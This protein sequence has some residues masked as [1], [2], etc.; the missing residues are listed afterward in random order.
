MTD[1]DDR[2]VAL[3]AEL[4]PRLQRPRIVRVAG[5]PG[6]AKS[7]HHPVTDGDAALEL[8][9]VLLAVPLGDDP[10]RLG[11]VDERLRP[12]VERVPLDVVVEQLRDR[13][14]VPVDERAVPADDDL[15]RLQAHALSLA[16]TCRGIQARSSEGARS[17]SFVRIDSSSWS[18]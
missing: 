13:V 12:G 4:A 9:A 11:V 10:E 14:E 5:F 17:P 1:R 2:G 16:W 7:D 3:D 15:D 6:R 18:S 8:D